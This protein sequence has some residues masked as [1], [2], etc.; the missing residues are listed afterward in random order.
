MRCKIALRQ[1][2]SALSFSFLGASVA[3]VERE[4]GDRDF[5]AR[6]VLLLGEA[7]VPDLEVLLPAPLKRS[8]LGPCG[9]LERTIWKIEPSVGVMSVEALIS[10]CQNA[11]RAA[12]SFGMNLP[13]FLA[14]VNQDRGGLRHGDRLAARAF[15]VDD[16]RD[17]RVRIERRELR[18]LVLAFSRARSDA[19][20]KRGRI[21]RAR[22]A[23]ACRSTFLRRRDRS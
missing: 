4:V 9:S 12:G 3:G 17:L 7:V 16:H 19:A 13:D 22:C 10:A 1:N 14:G 18:R 2:F 6:G 15:V 23:R 5:V 8:A 21:P 11:A 20:C